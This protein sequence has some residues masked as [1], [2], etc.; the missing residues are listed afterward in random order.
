MIVI[1]K[2]YLNVD[3]YHLYIKM[4]LVI[5][6]IVVFENDISIKII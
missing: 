1:I 2:F 5:K 3:Y 4:R 6:V